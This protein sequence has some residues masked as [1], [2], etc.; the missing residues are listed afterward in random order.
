MR[1]HRISIKNFRGVDQFDLTFDIDGVTIVEGDNEIG[2]SC[3][4]EALALV[5]ETLDSSKSKHVTVIKPV[6]RD[7]G[8]EVEVEISSGAYQFVLAKRWLKQASTTLTISC[9]SREQLTGR[10]AH[11][12]VQAI[13]TETLDRDLW[14]ALNV[15]QGGD[16]ALPNFNVPALGR[17]LDAASGGAVSTP[18]DE[19]LWD[20]I[21]AERALYWTPSGQPN[22]S[23]KALAA[24][25][26]QAQDAVEAIRSDLAKIDADIVEVE[27]LDATL[28]DLESQRD[29]CET[30]E[31]ELAERGRIAQ[32]A[33]A[34]LQAAKAELDAATSAHERTIEKVGER[35]QL[36]D[37]TDKARAD[38]ADLK[39]EQAAAE[40][41]VTAA[42]RRQDDARL[43]VEQA[44]A[45]RDAAEQTLRLAAGDAAYMRRKTEVEELTERAEQVRTAEAR[46]AGAEEI[47]DQIRLTTEA[48]EDIDRR[49]LDSVR[50]AAA[51]DLGAATLRL[52]TLAA[53]RLTIGEDDVELASGTVRAVSVPATLD[54]EIPGVLRLSV[55][56]G[57]SA[58]DL[59]AEAAQLD[60]RYLD[61]CRDAGV[62][63]VADARMQLVARQAAENEAANARA[64]IQVA[65]RD[66]TPDALA[67]KITSLGRS[68][69]EYEAERSSQLGPPSSA[70]E[71]IERE[72]AAR[73]TLADRED[74]LV[75]KTA[76]LEALAAEVQTLVIDMAAAG[77]TLAAAERALEQLDQR[78]AEARSQASDEEL[79]AAARV[80]EERLGGATIAFDEAERRVMDDDPD[81]LRELIGNA[82]AATK[83]LA[84][85]IRSAV[86]R[87]TQAMERL[88]L[89]GNDGLQQKLD[90]ALTELRHLEYE[91]EA[92]ERRADA[93]LLLDDVAAACREDMR[94]RYQGPFRQQIERF[95]RILFDD[96][97]EVELDD[98]LRI[99]KR[100]LGG[101][102]LEFDQLSAGARE[103]LGIVSRLA[104]ATIVSEHGGAPVVLDDT[105]GWTDPTRLS[106][107][108]AIIALA[109]KA[110]QVIVLTCTPGRYASIGDAETVRLPTAVLAH[111]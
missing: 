43:A 25:V 66:L 4:P 85:E 34:G 97:F 93:A 108:G 6:H 12:R 95:G 39:A 105:L 52:E 31:V 58:Q 35:Q 11:D 48:L 8:P 104:C 28:P 64:A 7:V 16:L 21:V 1:L 107:M 65:L 38:L 57:N 56:A 40:P 18:H 98:D 100:T 5:L 67:N 60:E 68:I 46:L 83:R 50:A 9:P 70:D 54:L 63:D 82:K 15:Q 19:N 17:A 94:R 36:N 49:H 53:T 73:E 44:R 69:A 79:V 84:A 23:R 27:R 80:A 78:L 110:C 75:A 96:T 76:I 3:I 24:D 13:L 30:K 42:R 2:K 91:H 92:L 51:L 59:A 72:H 102:T 32:L 29:A 87:R 109:G 88:A 74:E 71:A 55:A 111:V 14:A 62:S 86:E 33:V 61:A 77:A 89:R 101:I 22:A 20:R 10:E 37:H 45:G 47:I 90:D 106:A 103:Q 99:A 26:T 41:A 81:L